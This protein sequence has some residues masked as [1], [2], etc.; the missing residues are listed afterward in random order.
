MEMH[1]LRIILRLI[2]TTNLSI[3]EICYYVGN[4]SP[5]TVFH[6]QEVFMKRKCDWQK[7]EYLVMQI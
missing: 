2:L 4:V 3:K 1:I 6:I 7:S 5:I